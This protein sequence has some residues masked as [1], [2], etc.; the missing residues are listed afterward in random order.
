M[1][2]TAKRDAKK[3]AADMDRE[4]LAREAKSIVALAFRN[5]PIED[6]H[7][8]KACSRCTGKA[9]YSHITDEEMKMLMKSAVDRV[10]SLLRMKAESPAE[11]ELR[12]Q[13]GTLYTASWDDPED[14]V[15]F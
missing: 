9:E 6:I 14:K 11:Y 15:T 7:A 8:G 5:G 3:S 1:K 13:F 4:S 12:I 10:Y 2:R